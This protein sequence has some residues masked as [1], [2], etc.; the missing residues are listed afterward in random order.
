V[1]AYNEAPASPSEVAE[2]L[3]E[4][5]GNVAYHTERLLEHGCLELVGTAPGRGGTKHTY[6][7]ILRYESRTTHGASCHG[8]CASLAG[9]AVSEIGRGVTA[10]RPSAASATTR[11]LA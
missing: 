7:A 10:G 8:H 2:R 4:P 3:G 1:I 9:R 6:R 5:L 11:E